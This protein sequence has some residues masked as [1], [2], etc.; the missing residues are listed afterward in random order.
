M[1]AIINVRMTL[2]GAMLENN[3][4]GTTPSSDAFKIKLDF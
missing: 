4:D 2:S 3:N 1:V